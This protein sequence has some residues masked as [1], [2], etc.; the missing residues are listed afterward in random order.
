[1]Y[2]IDVYVCMCINVYMYA[3]EWGHC[4][5]HVCLTEGRFGYSS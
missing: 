4:K 1:M 5:C 3:D 2:S